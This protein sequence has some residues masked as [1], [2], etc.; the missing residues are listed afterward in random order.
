MNLLLISFS[1]VVAITSIV[2]INERL[3]WQY[4]TL[5]HDTDGATIKE[6][7]EH[8]AR[9]VQELNIAASWEEIKI[10]LLTK[11]EPV[12]FR[13]TSEQASERP[14]TSLPLYFEPNFLRSV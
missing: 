11:K 3:N 8:F 2:L 13:W 12:K 6:L 7:L 10:N 14:F 9:P 1:I 5:P 4:E